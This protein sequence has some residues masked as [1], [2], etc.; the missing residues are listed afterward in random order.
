LLFTALRVLGVERTLLVAWRAC[1]S[2]G[3][4]ALLLVP[5]SLPAEAALVYVDPSCPTCS[6]G[7]LRTTAGAPEGEYLDLATNLVYRHAGGELVLVGVGLPNEGYA[8]IT[9]TNAWGG[10][11]SN[12]LLQPCAAGLGYVSPCAQ[13]ACHTIHVALTGCAEARVTFTYTFWGDQAY[14]NPSP[15]RVYPSPCGTGTPLPP[16]IQAPTTP[17]APLKGGLE[18]GAT[19]PILTTGD[20]T[21][22]INDAFTVDVGCWHLTPSG[23]YEKPGVGPVVHEWVST[24]LLLNG[25]TLG[26]TNIQ[27]C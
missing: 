21:T 20:A 9:T 6:A 26:V 16:P 19:R 4:V 14:A 17:P 7:S 18:G 2:L 3:A 1:A 24:R 8:E 11:S 12:S 15:D 23:A 27:I 10:C 25:R 5:A 22:L 13:Q